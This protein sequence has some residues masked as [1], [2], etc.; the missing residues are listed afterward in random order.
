MTCLEDYGVIRTFKS[1]PT[2]GIDKGRMCCCML[3]CSDVLVLGF[4]A[5][6]RITYYY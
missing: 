4:G 2:R 1:R 3:C 6:M 5:L